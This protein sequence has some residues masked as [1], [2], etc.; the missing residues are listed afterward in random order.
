MVWV[1]LLLLKSAEHESHLLL[2]VENGDKGDTL[3]PFF[4]IQK[5][6]ICKKTESVFNK[7]TAQK[8][9]EKFGTLVRRNLVDISLKWKEKELLKNV[10]NYI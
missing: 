3:S 8:K 10:I 7:Q 6:D 9:D 2:T 5:A 4:C 1:L